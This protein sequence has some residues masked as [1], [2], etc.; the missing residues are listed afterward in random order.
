MQSKAGACPSHFLA[1][2]K[3]YSYPASIGEIITIFRD[4]V[5]SPYSASSIRKL[6][7]R[8]TEMG[9]AP[10]SRHPRPCQRRQ[11]VGRQP[12]GRSRQVAGHQPPALILNGPHPSRRHGLQV[13]DPPG[14][15]ANCLPRHGRSS[16]SPDDI[17]LAH[18]QPLDIAIMRADASEPMSSRHPHRGRATPS[19][20]R[21]P[22]PGPSTV[23]GRELMPPTHHG[24]VLHAMNSWVFPGHCSAEPGQSG[25]PGQF[26]TASTWSTGRRDGRRLRVARHSVLVPGGTCPFPAL[27]LPSG[28]RD[29]KM[30]P[31]TVERPNMPS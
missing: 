29:T 15:C 31:T 17:A 1:S 24:K 10:R 8:R 25:A 19:P 22:R 14:S 18:Y 7:R 28:L 27:A 2:P 23:K 30:L 12:E 13:H 9:D 11:P 21:G 4:G 26:F 16:S 20:V 5:T 6:F 3:A